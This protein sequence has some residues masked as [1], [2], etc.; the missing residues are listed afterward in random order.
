MAE[1]R[2][3][4]VLFLCTGNSA[5]SI[6]A[7]AALARLG[8]DRFE[9]H[10][11]GSEP[12]AAP[13]PRT[14]ETLEA[15]G[16][17]TGAFRSKSWD[18]FAAD[19]APPIDVVITVCGNAANETCPAWPGAPIAAHW[20][21]EDPAAFEGTEAETLDFFAAIH[22]ELAAKIEAFVELDFETIP[23]EEL[24]EHVRAIADV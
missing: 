20:G 13:H 18:V 22:D 11:A 3:I 10:S 7:E 14:L 9:S 8:G 15:R 5:R 19:D 21:V 17:Q 4:G 16:Y 1:A 2:P 12:K 6:L 23:R 24:I